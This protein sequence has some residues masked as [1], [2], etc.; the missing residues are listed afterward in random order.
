[1][2]QLLKHT[3]IYGISSILGRFLNALMTPIINNVLPPNQTGISTQLYLY[4]ALLMVILIYG[5]ETTAFRFVHKKNNDENVLETISSLLWISTIFFCGIIYAFATPIAQLLSI[6]DPFFV[7]ISIAIIAFDVL[8]VMSFVRL[9]LLNKPF[10]FAFIKLANIILTFFLTTLFLWILPYYTTLM[11]TIY[12][13]FWANVI[14]SFC[15]LLYLLFN[16]S[17]FIAFKVDARLIKQLLKF[18]IPIMMTGLAVMITQVFGRSI[19]QFVL[20]LPQAEIDHIFGIFSA[21]MKM[22]IVMTIFAQAF[23]MGAEPFFFKSALQDN[24]PKIYAMAMHYFLLVSVL[25]FVF[26]SLFVDIFKY[27]IGSSLYWQGLHIVPLALFS[28][29]LAGIYYN[30]SIWYKLTNHLKI[31]MLI[32]ILGAILTILLNILLIPLISYTGSVVASIISFMVMCLSSWF[33]GKRYYP[34]PYNIA[35][36]V[37]YV[38]LGVTIVIVALIVR[39]YITNILTIHLIHIMLLLIFLSIILIKENTMRRF[40]LHKCKLLIKA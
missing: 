29:L 31:A 18:G 11:P 10:N 34:I 16:S 33:I 30:L 14:V 21:N 15:T 32:A 40:L 39:H 19:M 26:V 24:A 37:Q 8:S 3:A 20:P 28:E 9:R 23:R 22:A 7:K 27:Y 5:M 35:T 12:H 13:I 6:N 17:T 25:I 2:L 4:I 38:C 36:M 1:M